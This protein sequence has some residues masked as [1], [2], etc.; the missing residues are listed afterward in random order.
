MPDWPAWPSLRTGQ[1]VS[2]YAARAIYEFQEDP[3]T[4]QQLGRL[5]MRSQRTPEG[6]KTPAGREAKS[7]REGVAGFDLTFSPPK[8]VSALWAL[9]GP[10][11]Q[12]RL[13]EAHRQATQE[14]LE[15]VEQNVIQSRAGHAGV[16]HVAVRGMVASMFDHWDSRAGDPQLHTDVVGRQSACSE[17]WMISG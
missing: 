15:W 2:Q 12:G 5:L 10:E 17:S 9:A 11:L 16:A 3:A 6:A 1:Q 7:Q 8:S 14:T 4:G 13:H